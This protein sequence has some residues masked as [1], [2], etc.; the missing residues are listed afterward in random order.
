MSAYI[1]RRIMQMIPALLLIS[2][3]V[4]MLINLVPGDPA[5]I[6]AG[7]NATQ[8]RLDA[9]RHRF[10]LDQPLLTRYFLWLIN[11]LSGDMG[12]TAISG[13]PV[14]D[15]LF[16]RLPGTLEL[17]IMAVLV[18]LLLSVPL[19]LRS[20]LYP[21]RRTDRLSTLFSALFSAL[22][23]FF[24]ALLLMLV[25]CVALSL[26]PPSGRP[27]LADEP[28][29]HLKSLVLPATTLAVGMAAATL[30]YLRSSMIEALGQDY[31]VT[32]RAKGLGEWRIVWRHALRNA[33]VPTL[34]VV[35]IQFGELLGGALIIESIFGWPGVGRLTIQAIAWRDYALLQATVLYIVVGFMLT[36]L[37]ADLL[38]ATLD[39]RVRYT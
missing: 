7:A 33:L 17:A 2:F 25:F 19:G 11:I 31:I 4:Y 1:A 27:S 14:A 29:A 38:I 24:L 12:Y 3:V 32:A 20:G 28:L 39:P 10:G 6:L 22:P 34:T 5:Q 9:L 18:S 37:A 8:E 23:G 35:S 15:V 26:L 16:E 21:G 36:S 30:R 13:R